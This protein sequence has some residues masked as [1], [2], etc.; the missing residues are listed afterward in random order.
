MLRDM[1]SQVG[2]YGR[3]K[4]IGYG[5][6]TDAYKKYGECMKKYYTDENPT[7]TQCQKLFNAFKKAEDYYGRYA[8]R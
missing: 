6:L 1:Q 7:P 2:V 8:S 4:Q 3:L 5:P